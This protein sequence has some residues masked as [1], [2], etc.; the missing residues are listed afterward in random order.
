MTISAV[1]KKIS[2]ITWFF[3]KCHNVLLDLGL[4]I[5]HLTAPNHAP[6]FV[7]PQVFAC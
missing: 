3:L 2:T 6:G 7:L 5:G 4:N 1:I